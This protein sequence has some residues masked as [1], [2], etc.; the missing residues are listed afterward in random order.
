MTLNDF[1]QEHDD[2]T[3]AA[4][5]RKWKEF[6]SI[7]SNLHVETIRSFLDDDV[8]GAFAEVESMDGFGTEGMDL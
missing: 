8:L 6:C 1:I 3:D 2:L 4:V 5:E 7:L